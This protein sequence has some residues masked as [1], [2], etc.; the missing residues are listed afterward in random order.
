[1]RQEAKPI[2]LKTILKW[3]NLETIEEDQEEVKVNL[4]KD[5]NL[6]YYNIIDDFRQTSTNIFFEDLMKIGLYHKS[7]Q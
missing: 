7:M 3:L 2:I 4:K 5:S 1:M 6:Y